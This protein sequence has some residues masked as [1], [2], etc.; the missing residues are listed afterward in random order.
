MRLGTKIQLFSSLFMLVLILLINT[1]IYSLFYEINKNSEL[2]RLSDRANTIVTTL[3]ANPAIAEKELLSAFIPM[4]GMIRVFEKNEAKPLLLLTKKSD[5][6]SFSGNFSPSESKRIVKDD[7]KVN[8]AV[9]EKPIIWKNG[10]I[11]TLQVTNH[12][13]SL[14][15][16]MKTLFYVLLVASLFILIP[17]VI[18]GTVLSKFLLLPIKALTETMKENTNQRNWQKIDLENRSKD[19]LYEMEKTFNDMI[20]H[21]KASYEQQETFVSNASHELK[22]PISIVKSYAQLMKRRGI[23]HPEVMIESIQ[24]IDGEADRMQKLVEQMLLLAKSDTEFPETPVDLG[25]LCKETVHTFQG[26]YDRNI[27]LSLQ[28]EDVT[29]VGNADQLQQV[30][31]ILIDNA[32]KYS[33]DEVKLILTK[34]DM[35]AELSIQDKGEGISKSEQKHI[36]DRYYRLDKARS[37]ETGGTGLGLAIAKSIT[38]AHQGDLS[39]ESIQGIGSVFK[40]SFPVGEKE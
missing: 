36:F 14:Q 34:T 32:L 8:V 17:T 2:E 1:A 20:D 19:E 15:Q 24:A 6:T 26:A 22:T 7:T 10:D 13:V 28:A 18:A 9:I 30:I 11:V 25:K 3:N 16:T 39:V 33:E 31:Y 37:R 23:D 27:K 5:Y 21:L 35:K 38:E 4:N 40:L 29:I 12:L